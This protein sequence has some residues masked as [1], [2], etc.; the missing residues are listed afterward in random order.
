MVDNSLEHGFID[1]KK[2]KIGIHVASNDNNDVIIS[3][4]NDGKRISAEEKNAVFE[5]FFSTQRDRG[6]IGL[7]LNVIHNTITDSYNGTINLI[8]SPI[9]VRYEIII[10]HFD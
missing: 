7:D 2:E 6:K 8:D 4:Q 5:P 1:F 9:G 3:Y 10:P